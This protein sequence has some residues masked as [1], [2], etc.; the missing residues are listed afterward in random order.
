MSNGNGALLT[1]GKSLLDEA[2]VTYT[3][4]VTANTGTSTKYVTI[5][6]YSSPESS[7]V[8]TASQNN[9][10]NNTKIYGDA[11]RETSTVGIGSKSWNSD[12]SYFPAL[13]I[14]SFERGGAV[15]VGV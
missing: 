14:P 12:Y 3:T 11:V 10:A 15:L 7:T 4:T 1:Y 5:Y 6:P 8:D 2:K 13:S 9:F